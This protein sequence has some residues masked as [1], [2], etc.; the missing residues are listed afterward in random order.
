MVSVVGARPQFVKL[1]PLARAL[2]APPKK[3][4]AIRHLILH[5]GQ[6]YDENMSRVFFDEPMIPRPA[7]DLGVGSGSHARQTGEMLVGIERV[8]LEARPDVV[9]VY[10][11]TNSTLAGALAAAKL[12]IRLAHVE[13]GLRSYNRAMPEEIN[14]EVTDRVSDFLFCPTRTAVENLKREGFRTVSSGACIKAGGREPSA[15]NVG[16]IMYD[17]VLFNLNLAGKKSRIIEDLGLEPPYYLVTV[18]RA[19]STDNPGNLENIISALG[20]V[21]KEGMRVVFP[22]HPRTRKVIEKNSPLRAL[23]RNLLL[24]DPLPYL[25]MLWLEKN[26]SLILTDSGGVQKEAYWLRIPCLTLRNE[27]EWPETIEAGANKLVGYEVRQILK[28][29]R[30]LRPIKKKLPEVFGNGRTAE[31]IVKILSSVQYNRTT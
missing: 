1:S 10:G 30:S 6:H 13:A 12:G 17:S 28:A 18:H 29:V 20:R 25:D 26:A 24:I 19:E 16:D 23:A 3:K 8:L 31:K 21:A 2:A 7:F 15:V 27:T 14:R 4:P 5:T 22:V 9:L 11:D